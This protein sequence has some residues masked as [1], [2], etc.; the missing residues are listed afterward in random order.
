MSGCDEDDFCTRFGVS[1]PPLP[2]FPGQQFVVRAHDPPPPPDKE[3]DG[4]EDPTYNHET[5]RE[6]SDIHPHDR[7]LLYPPSKG[8]DG[9]QSVRFEIVEAI[10]LGDRQHAQLALVRVLENSS[11]NDPRPDTVLVAKFYDALYCDHRDDDGDHVLY[12]DRDY[13]HEVAA[14]AAM[15]ELQGDT[16]PR[17]YGPYTLELPAKETTR[18][19]RL[20]LMNQTPGISMDKLSPSAFSQRERQ[21]ILQKIITSETI[22]HGHGIYHRDTY[23]RNIMLDVREDTTIRVC[24]IDFGQSEVRSGPTY[25]G[26]RLEKK[27]T[28]GF[29]VSPILRWCKYVSRPF[30]FRDWIDWDWQPWLEETYQSTKET[31]T[32]EVEEIWGPPACIVETAHLRPWAII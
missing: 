20:I 16:V 11:S 23:P 2:Y 25:A 18:L 6:R 7:C 9:S 5:Y 14:Y 1:K 29:Q 8:T 13:I 17:Y 27:Y 3:E 24:F 22:L 15:H 4:Y 31:I 21:N 26:H 32:E 12:T 10:R 30:N 28:R 19:V